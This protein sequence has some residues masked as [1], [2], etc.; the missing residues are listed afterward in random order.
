MFDCGSQ[1]TY[2]ANRIK[3][4]GEEMAG[5]RDR[6]QTAILSVLTVGALLVLCGGQEAVAQD[7]DDCQN[8]SVLE[9]PPEDCG[10][11]R[12]FFSSKSVENAV[13]FSYENAL[14]YGVTN[15]VESGTGHFAAA[16]GRYL[17][18]WNCDPENYYPAQ[19]APEDAYCLPVRNVRR[20]VAS[21]PTYAFPEI[22]DSLEVREKFA[23]ASDLEKEF[24]LD[25]L[26]FYLQFRGVV[27]QDRVVRY[28][29]PTSK[30][31]VNVASCFPDGEGG[32][33][34]SFL[35]YLKLAIWYEDSVL[36]DLD[37]YGIE[38]LYSLNN[39]IEYRITH[40]IQVALDKS[41]GILHPRLPRG[42]EHELQLAGEILVD[43]LGYVGEMA[44]LPRPDLLPYIGPCVYGGYGEITLS[45]DPPGG[46]IFFMSTFQERICSLK[47]LNCAGEPLVGSDESLT[48]S[49]W[50]LRIDWPDGRSSCINKDYTGFGDGGSPEPVVIHHQMT[51]EC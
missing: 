50:F 44:N 20:V 33:G 43:Q 42:Y 48:A 36:S 17:T 5:L 2:P 40:A 29:M 3:P 8:V 4:V 18:K 47:G 1:L 12:V 21:F 24:L 23:S 31:M 28:T 10:Y 39:F 15:V 38:G 30:G 45:T 49:S 11:Y 41:A 35:D 27:L 51:R 34:A 9:T 19:E 13:L 22:S 7:T 37:A 25:P 32:E 16:S 14:K 6:S 26:G 46:Q